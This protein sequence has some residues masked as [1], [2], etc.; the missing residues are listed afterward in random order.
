MHEASKYT[1]MYRLVMLIDMHQRQAHLTTP[2]PAPQWG[3]R[4][5][6]LHLSSTFLNSAC[7]MGRSVTLAN[8][9]QPQQAAVQ[10][11]SRACNRSSRLHKARNA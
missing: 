10:Q 7:R 1:H 2:L 11:A 9:L 8:A 5:V 6:D 4:R 3:H